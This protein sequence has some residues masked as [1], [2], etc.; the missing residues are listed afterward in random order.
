MQEMIID[1]KDTNT[2]SNW[3]LK[4]A[5]PPDLDDA[6]LYIVFQMGCQLPRIS[7]TAHFKNNNDSH[8]SPYPWLPSVWNLATPEAWG[9]VSIW[10]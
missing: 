5:L 4:V 3:C 2:T 6:L 9:I 8:R 10:N 1:Q 7:N